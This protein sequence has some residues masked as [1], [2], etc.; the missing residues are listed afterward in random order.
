[1]GIPCG[2]T[3]A[4]NSID[5]PVFYSRTRDV[6]RLS[7]TRGILGPVAELLEK[8]GDEGLDW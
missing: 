2:D 1:M 7:H 8:K 3:I 4:C 6:A 5:C